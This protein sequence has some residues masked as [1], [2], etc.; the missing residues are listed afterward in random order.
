MAPD[1]NC[2]RETLQNDITS[3]Q[4]IGGYSYGFCY[5]L[6]LLMI[7]AAAVCTE[8]REASTHT[9]PHDIEDETV[10]INPMKQKVKPL[11]RVKNIGK[12]MSR[13]KEIYFVIVVHIFD[14]LTDF[15]I[16]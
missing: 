2:P 6:F 8:Y 3:I 5:G 7:F 9:A 16:M 10:P 14:T 12:R 4:T 11:K 13:L 15:L 1:Q